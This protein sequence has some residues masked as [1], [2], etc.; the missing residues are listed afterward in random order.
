MGPQGIDKNQ[1]IRLAE[2]S[3]RTQKYKAGDIRNILY[4]IDI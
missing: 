1:L 3:A 4:K 2:F